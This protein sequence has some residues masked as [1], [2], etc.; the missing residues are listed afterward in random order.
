MRYFWVVV[1]C[2]VKKLQFLTPYILNSLLFNLQFFTPPQVVGGRRR[3]SA[4]FQIGHKTS[5]LDWPTPTE[6][7]N[8]ISAGEPLYPAYDN[9]LDNIQIISMIISSIWSNKFDHFSGRP[10]RPSAW[11][12]TVSLANRTTRNFWWGCKMAFVS[13]I[14]LQKYGPR[15]CSIACSQSICYW[16]GLV[17]FHNFFIKLL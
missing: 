2:L 13:T 11:I 16:F 1:V 5:K 4:V 7:L 15:I 14:A 17:T 9:M 3:S 6:D 8:L 12:K 10:S